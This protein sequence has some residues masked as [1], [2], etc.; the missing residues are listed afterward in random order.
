MAFEF[1]Q[2]RSADDPVDP[3]FPI[4]GDRKNSVVLED[5]EQVLA[6]ADAFAVSGTLR[7]DGQNYSLGKVESIAGS[8]T[9][10]DSRVT[11]ACTDFKRGGGWSGY[12]A[13]G[14][15]VAMTANA[16]SNAN[17]RRKTRGYTL[18][19]H[20]RYEW[21]GAGGVTAQP[22]KWGKSQNVLKLVFID[23]TDSSR[24]GTLQIWLEKRE[25]PTALGQTIAAHAARHLAADA[26]EPLRSELDGIASNP[27]STP[28][29]AGNAVF[30]KIPGT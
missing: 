3:L 29:A 27:S 16:I 18:V 5:G 10:T 7:A 19:S 11:F 20:V 30:W 8:V 4:P 15:A 2:P 17:A 9:V 28:T 21:L 12:G 6:T 22:Y 26:S 14:I 24:V 23:P 13:A 25:Q 1:L